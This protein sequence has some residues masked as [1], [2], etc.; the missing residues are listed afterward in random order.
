MPNGNRRRRTIV[1]EGRPTQP[2]SRIPKSRSEDAPGTPPAGSRRI[3]AAPQV[4][5]SRTSAT[6]EVFGRIDTSSN[7]F[8]KG[9]VGGGS[10]LSGRMHDEDWVIFGATVPYSNTLSNPVNGDLAYGTFDVG[11][12]L[13]HGPSAKVGGFISYNYFKESK[14][15]FGCVQI[16]NAN[17]ER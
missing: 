8:L 13:F 9:F 14:S 4:S 5:R 17:S 11:Y 3:S 7:L 16:A 2:M 1:C 12:A 15:A 10:H 6:G